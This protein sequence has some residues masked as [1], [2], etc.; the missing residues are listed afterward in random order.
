MP[1][2]GISGGAFHQR[3]KSA[4]NP[5]QPSTWY[6]T[7]H[8]Q[9]TKVI[10]SSSN[11]KELPPRFNIADLNEVCGYLES[12]C[13]L[14]DC[15]SAETM[16]LNNQWST[17]NSP[18]PLYPKVS[19]QDLDLSREIT[20]NAG[21]VRLQLAPLVMEMSSA[22]RKEVN[23]LPDQGVLDHDMYKGLITLRLHVLKDKA[24]GVFNSDGDDQFLKSRSFFYRRR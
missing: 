8:C 19:D 5:Q 18:S 7:I 16:A 21:N 22:I 1:Y 4:P 9:Y 11:A 6:Y 10:M 14:A 2:L 3:S 20:R 13:R 17:L 15:S 23:K 24:Q 12:L